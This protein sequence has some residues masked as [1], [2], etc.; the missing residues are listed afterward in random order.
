MQQ[1][2]TRFGFSFRPKGERLNVCEFVDSL[3]W[4]LHLRNIYSYENNFFFL[5]FDLKMKWN[6]DDHELILFAQLQEFE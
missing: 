5:R 4:L 6:A 2:R 1:V 3:C